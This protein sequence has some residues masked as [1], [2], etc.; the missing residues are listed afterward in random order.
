MKGMVAFNRALL[1]KQGW[2]ILTCN[3]YLMSKTL[4]AKYFPT[5]SFLEAKVKGNSSFTW[6]SIL[7]AKD[8]I[9]G[10]SRWVVSN[11]KNIEI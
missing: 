6:R 10:G 9:I 7:A 5:S 2:R 4:K 3:S 8:L 1:V 11:G